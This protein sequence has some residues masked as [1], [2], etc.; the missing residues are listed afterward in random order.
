MRIKKAALKSMQVFLA[1]S[2]LLPAAVQA[3][4]P[5]WE[6][7][8]V[9]VNKRERMP[10]TKEWLAQ[11]AASPGSKGAS[12]N[13][14]APDEI[15]AYTDDEIKAMPWEPISAQTAILLK[16][17]LDRTSLQIVAWFYPQADRLLSH[18]EK[19]EKYGWSDQVVMEKVAS[20]SAQSYSLLAKLVPVAGERYQQWKQT[21]RQ[22][23]AQQM[24]SVQKEEG[25][26]PSKT[27][28]N[29]E[30]SNAAPSAVPDLPDA[31][32]DPEGL[33][34]QY[35]RNID[36]PVDE[37]H[38]MSNVAET[39]LYLEGKHG[40]DLKLERRYSQF[41][42]I[43]E[44]YY[45]SY[46]GNRTKSDMKYVNTYH[47][48]RGWKLNLPMF[49]EIEKVD[50]SCE[51]VGTRP[52]YTCGS[53]YV[54]KRYIFTLD[55]GTVLESSSEKG[56]WV[57]YPYQGAVMSGYGKGKTENGKKE[58]V[59]LLY[60]GYSYTFSKEDMDQEKYEATDVVTKT[61]VYGDT[62]VYKFPKNGKPIQITD[63]VGRYIEMNPN[64]VITYLK[65]YAD[66]TKT[67]LLKHIEYDWGGTA[68]ATDRIIERD[69][70]GSGSKLI[71]EYS[72]LDPTVFGT[73][74]FNLRASYYLPAT[75]K[76]IPLDYKGMENAT[77]HSEDTHTRG[78]ITYKLLRQ[79]RYP[80]EG[81]TM[82]YTYSPYQPNE[83][84]FLS[85]GVAR[86]YHDKEK[87][88]YTTYHPVTAVNIRFAKTPHPNRPKTET[89]AKT[90]YYPLTS[91]EIWKSK[92]DDSVRLKNQT[93]R[94]GA[95]AVSQT[96]Q[97]GVPSQ[98]KTFALNPDKNFLLRSA[99]SYIG[100]GANIDQIEGS[101][102]LTEGG[103]T[104][105]YHPVSYV[106]HLYQGRETKPAY[107]YEFAGKQP[108]RTE[109]VDVYQYLLA[110]SSDRLDSVKKR[111]PQYA[112]VTAYAYN[113]YGDLIKLVD[114]KG[115][116]STWTY[117]PHTLYY[118]R[119]LS[120]MSRTAADNP[121]HFHKEV[122][123]Y[124]SEKL[125]ATR[126]VLYSY[127]AGGQVKKD[128]VAQVFSYQNKLVSSIQQLTLGLDEKHLVQYIKS[129]DRY[130]LYPTR[131]EM[132]VETSPQVKTNLQYLFTYDELGR[133]T[134][135]LY[136]DQSAALY[137]YDYLGR[138]TSE[139]FTN[140]EEYR[141]ITYG[142]EDDKRKVT[143]TLPDGTQKIT[144]FTPYGEV[145]YEAQ[146][147][148]NGQIRPLQYNTFTPDGERLSSTAP[149]AIDSRGTVYL[150]NS[151]GTLWQMREPIGTTVYL[152]ANA[153]T[154]E[155][156]RTIQA[157]TN[158]SLSP[159]GLVITQFHDRFGQLGQETTETADGTQKR[160]AV[161]AYNAFR[162]PLQKTEQ[163]R[164]GKSRT[165]SYQYNPGDKLV[166][167]VDPEKNEYDYGYDVYGNLVTVSENNTLTTRYHYNALFWKLSEKDVPSGAEETFGY[168]PTGHLAVFTDKAGNRHEYAYTPFYE[169]ARL[170]T[171]NAAGTVK[172]QE[173]KEY[174]PNTSLVKRE[175]NSNGPNLSSAS[176]L[177]RE[178]SY[179]YDPFQRVDSFTAFGRLYQIRY[180][181]ADDQMDQLIY[182]GN[183][184][185]SYSYDDAMRLKTVTIPGESGTSKAVRYQYEL[186]NTGDSYTLTYPSGASLERKRDSF[187]QVD[188]TR[189]LQNGTAVW[190]EKQRYSFGNV[191]AI[192]RNGTTNT[193]EYDKI[194]RLTKE[195]MPLGTN[196]YSY[197]SRGN[198]QTF[199]G[200][201][202]EQSA[203]TTYSFDERNRLRSASNETTGAT[204][205]YTYHPD[206]LRATRT[207]G[208]KETRYVY[209]NGK[210]IEELDKNNQL[211]ARN[212]WGNELLFRKDTA[213]NK[214][215]YYLYNSHGDVVKIVG[216]Q[217]E[218]LNRYEYDTWGNIVSKRE[219]MS[220]PFAYS[221][222][223]F[224]S[225][226]GFYYLRARYY[227]PTVGRFIS[228]DT[229]K[230]QVDN[231][232]SLNR[233]T[234]VSN[235]PLRFI[236][237][238]G[239]VN[240]NAGSD[241]G[242]WGLTFLDWNRMS[243]ET[244]KMY[245]DRYIKYGPDSIPK[246][247]KS[248]VEIMAD[249]SGLI[250]GAGGI[251]IVR[252][253]GRATITAI[254][255]LMTATNLS[256]KA[257]SSLKGI[258]INKFVIKSKHLD[259]ANNTSSWRK[260]N[261]GTVEEAQE[262]VKSILNNA[263]NNTNM[264]KSVVDNGF[265]SKGQQSFSVWIDAG[266]VIG[267]KG[268][269]AIR[270]VYD[271]IGNIWTVFPDKLPKN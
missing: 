91:K 261:V 249:P 199:E 212:I 34:Y 196:R 66:A 175:T 2:L 83:P 165:W 25:L 120:E 12:V 29:R 258:D 86:L 234:Y 167:L 13:E 59:T 144:H 189:H 134:G 38:R 173:T 21:E 100:T 60:N 267:S 253:S 102:N 115:N 158:R 98:E 227:D 22:S 81:L 162:Q 257:I 252:N 181:D 78:Q 96:V 224:D 195:S 142:Y 159:N 225:E 75:N 85:R 6:K 213:A 42:A 244:R 146:V 186:S 163:E 111:L 150:Y 228:E 160:T 16:N 54:G 18:E 204:A 40:L 57:N 188:T 251:K 65:L 133:V 256:G 87:L 137:Q 194:D 117:L 24:P 231:P 71:A 135:R 136:P 119:Q 103:K 203:P 185:V 125:L 143:M 36:A 104:Y 245:I 37:V 174:Y 90:I 47:M 156:G 70:K 214:Q 123:T 219:G 230:G 148:T 223:M 69:T 126:N 238:S 110:P 243:E 250:P 161:F 226:T 118:L 93:I 171:K 215:G 262:M 19:V 64:G 207:A 187:G 192:E 222:E 35:K 184:A 260:F 217:G 246:G 23:D 33:T 88:T 30:A 127:P 51:Y 151:D 49:E 229:Y 218:E 80:V 270:I 73:T 1:L 4:G 44:R 141:S 124:N 52:E 157:E 240:E 178:L 266:R 43:Q 271:E 201:L 17:E 76:V 221:S 255:G 3:Q 233:Y 101:L 170:T 61:N 179:T 247:L 26:A 74:E 53:S 27:E 63:S 269:S 153:Y 242:Y 140:E 8:A 95:V 10:D 97:E 200:T 68:T 264:I 94:D 109:D 220:N 72:Y 210:V 67:K 152:R 205:S 128:S 216:E 15:P 58:I 239:H 55:D 105:R 129:Y 265:G 198:R 114:P 154:D 41:D 166:R 268:E 46:N 62:I 177:Y 147:G 77:Y 50:A 237:P 131:I 56:D 113:A 180:T 82:T 208:G 84:D 89:Y 235:N 168:T 32:Y 248:T 190:T 182:P 7:N 39:D 202:P 155:A 169:L 112:Q 263:K 79:V 5:G 28:T 45:Y 197:N 145:E 149:Y 183:A 99:K 14:L 241:S 106:S 132:E 164:S 254:N 116:T 31:V 122:Y 130:G 108:A 9:M 92:K 176:P 232:L 138:L 107:S 236:D 206:G 193:Y 11:F 259:I 209:L 48:P 20:L 172:N 191:I 139:Y 211:Q 121:E